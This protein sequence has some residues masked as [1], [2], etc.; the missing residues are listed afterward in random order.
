MK[1]LRAN[2]NHRIDINTGK[3]GRNS[4]MSYRE[5]NAGGIYWITTELRSIVYN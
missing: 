1:T 5:K 4:N 2:A 3:E